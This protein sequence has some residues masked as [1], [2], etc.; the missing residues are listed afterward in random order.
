MSLIDKSIEFRNRARR[1]I[2]GWFKPSILA[3]ERYRED[4][5]RSLQKHW[6]DS[7]I[8]VNELIRENWEAPTPGAPPAAANGADHFIVFIDHELAIDWI[9]NGDEDETQLQG[10]SLAESIGA[11]RCDHLPREQILE[12]RRL[13]G[14]A[15][16]NAIRGD[17]KQS[18]ALSET[19]AQFLKDRTVERSRAWTLAS[20]H[21]LLLGAAVPRSS[22]LACRSCTASSPVPPPASGSPLLAASSGRTFRSFKKRAAANGMP[23]PAS[24]FTSSRS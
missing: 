22:V 2:F 8:K 24:A 10:I 23:P 4:L 19:A 16:V 1:L 7:P 6:P 3:A 18:R 13:L 15:I 9:N 14:Q 11:R 21:S 5:N 20:A 17:A 12:F